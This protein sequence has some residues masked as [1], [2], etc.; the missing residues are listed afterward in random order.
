MLFVLLFHLQVSGF[1]YGY[2]GVDIF[3]V[4]SGFLITGIIAKNLDSGERWYKKFIIARVNRITPPLIVTVFIATIFGLFF[5]GDALLHD[6]S[7]SGLKSFY[8][9]SN[10]YFYSSGGYFDL[11]NRERP[12]L[13]TWTLSVELQF[14]FLWATLFFIIGSRSNK[15]IINMLLVL[16]S[17]SMLSSLVAVFFYQM[18]R[19]V[20]FLMPFRLYEFA[21]GGLSFY[22]INIVKK[23]TDRQSIN[24]N[25]LI[26]SLSTLSIFLYFLIDAVVALNISISLLIF[27]LILR[28]ADKNFR[29]NIFFEKLVKS[30]SVNT[31]TIYLVHFTVITFLS[32]IGFEQAELIFY[33]IFFIL[34]FTFLVN[35][36]V[37][38]IRFL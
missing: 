38:L 27:I 20:F 1:E 26:I 5:F 17:L 4:I 3:F 29:I 37:R 8:A 36:L 18:E 15:L 30:L 33:S 28:F 9:M 10:H 34:L 35:Y 14:Y 19:A 16:I 7:K 23:T 21:L 12:L 31:Y 2:L 11:L 24:Y 32:Y 6:L 13:H 25:H 22:M